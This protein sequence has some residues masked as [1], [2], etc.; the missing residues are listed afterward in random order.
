MFLN[1][2]QLLQSSYLYLYI[3]GPVDNLIFTIIWEWMPVHLQKIICL[4]INSFYL[5]NI[6]NTC[7]FSENTIYR[8]DNWPIEDVNYTPSYTQD[9]T[10]SKW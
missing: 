4:F 3:I 5:P 7:L 9:P 2:A 8:N 1:I 10:I 6:S